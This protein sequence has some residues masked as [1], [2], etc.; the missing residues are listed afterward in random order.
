MTRPHPVHRATGGVVFAAI[1]LVAGPAVA[2][3]QRVDL[4]ITPAS[5]TFPSADPDVMPVVSAP[6]LTVRYRVQQ[7]QGAQ[8]RITVLAGG[9]LVSGS[10]AIPISNVTWSATP[11]PPFQNGT[12]NSAVE[13]LV[14]SD[15]GNTATRTG[16]ITFSLVN[17]WNY[18]A[19]VY[20]Q[21]FVFTITAP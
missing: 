19:G 15:A 5:V 11:A 12:M 2:Y 9:D 13:Q 18:A 7:N 14:A 21:S 3:A 8:W 10:A 16:T 4:T 20:S 6:A 1:L 17:S